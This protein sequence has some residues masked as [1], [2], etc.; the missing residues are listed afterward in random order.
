MVNQADIGSI[1]RLSRTTVNA[2]VIELER[3]G[4]IRTGYGSV[5]I[6]DEEALRE[7]S[8]GD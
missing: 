4:W 3:R 5:Q 1:A 2:A 6:I 7:F 8:N